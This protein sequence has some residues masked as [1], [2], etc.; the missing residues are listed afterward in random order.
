[1]FNLGESPWS[2]TYMI[3]GTMP[4]YYIIL[5]EHYT[6]CLTFPITNWSCDG[7][8]IV[9]FTCL[10]NAQYGN[11]IWDSEIGQFNGEMWNYKH[12]VA[13][14][15]IMLLTFSTIGNLWTIFKERNCEQAKIIY[16]HKYFWAQL[17][18]FPISYL[19]F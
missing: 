11:K 9:L 2:V 4:F 8:F 14:F 12:F 18:F 5:E 10:I 6:D 15:I 7:M 17:I 16:E 13:G 1:M 19:T 3:S